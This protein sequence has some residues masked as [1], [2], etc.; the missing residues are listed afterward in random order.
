MTNVLD[1]LKQFIETFDNYKD[2]LKLLMYHKDNMEEI[3]EIKPKIRNYALKNLL[4][5]KNESNILKAY[6]NC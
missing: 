2:L 1:N 5:E 3:L 4:W 6:S